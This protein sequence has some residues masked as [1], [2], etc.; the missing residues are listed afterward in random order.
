MLCC[1]LRFSSHSFCLKRLLIPRLFIRR[2]STLS[3]KRVLFTTS[4]WPERARSAAS[5]RTLSLAEIL[6]KDGWDVRFC[7]P[8]NENAQASHLRKTG[9]PT[10]HCLPNDPEPFRR[11]LEEVKPNVVIFDTFVMEEH[12]HVS[13]KRE[14]SSLHINY[15]VPFVE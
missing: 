12:V 13:V 8:M 9:Y 4:Y 15:L 6:K 7:S 5:A 3:Q 2:Y 11:T 14:I 1:Q 10:Y